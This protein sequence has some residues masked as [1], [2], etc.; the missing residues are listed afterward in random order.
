MT[1]R[2]KRGK[3]Q[4]EWQDLDSGKQVAIAVLGAAQ[5][6]L[7]GI[8]QSKL[9]RRDKELVRGPKWLW[10]FVNLINFVGPIAFLSF[11][12]RSSPKS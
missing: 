12:R 3:A 7:L 5:I 1:K 6:T 10:F 11:G 2:G 9:L 4:T 8:A